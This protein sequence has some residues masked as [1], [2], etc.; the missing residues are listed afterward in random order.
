MLISKLLTVFS[1]FRIASTLSFFFF[2]RSFLISPDS[3]IHIRVKSHAQ[4]RMSPHHMCTVGAVN[5]VLP[6]ALS[7]AR[8][9]AEPGARI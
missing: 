9:S 4:G 6:G 3:F 5:V 7:R 8:L 1:T 2:L